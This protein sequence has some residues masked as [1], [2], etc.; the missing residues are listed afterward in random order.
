MRTYVATY[1]LDK[2]FSLEFEFKK[3]LSRETKY[4][5][6]ESTT[7]NKT[8]I[9]VTIVAQNRL[10]MRFLKKKNNKFLKGLGKVELIVGVG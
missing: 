1:K 5:F 4:K 2:P 3:P 8:I 7:D 10:Q 9:Y 6:E